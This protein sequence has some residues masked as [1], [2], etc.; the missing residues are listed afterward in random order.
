MNLIVVVD[1]QNGMMFNRRRQSR[2][3]VLCEKIL[4]M[5]HGSKLWMSEYT[6]GLFKDVDAQE[7]IVVDDKFLTRAGEEDYCFAENTLPD[8]ADVGKIIIF[9]W[10]R[11]YPGDFFFNIDLSSWRL[12]RAEDFAGSSHKNITVEVYER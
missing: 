2:D 4:S 5:T 9:R 12:T 3:R 10:N 8:A 11:R 6:S 7:Q 1:D